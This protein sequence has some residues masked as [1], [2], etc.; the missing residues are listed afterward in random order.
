MNEANGGRALIRGS[1]GVAR[2][3]W[4]GS[5]PL[6]QAY[7]DREWGR[8]LNGDDALFE[9]LTLEGFQAGLAWITILRKRE[10]F[11]EAFRGFRIEAVAGFEEGDVQRLLADARIV[12][13]RAKIEAA[14]ANARAALRLGDR[15]DRLTRFLWS[16]APPPRS[17]RVASADRIPAETSES[18]ALSKALRARGFRFV[19]PTVVYA[20]MQAVGMVDDHL[21]GCEITWWVSVA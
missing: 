8:P 1:D 9:M 12:R 13:N 20:F 15:E 3:W 21:A 19:G 7:H 17:G 18:R 2:C 14:I 5:D 11:R 6:Y 16:F 10:A 4:A